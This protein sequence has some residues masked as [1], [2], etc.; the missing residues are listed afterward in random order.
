M[1]VKSAR[2]PELPGCSPG[3]RNNGGSGNSGEHFPKKAT[4]AN[5]RSAVRWFGEFRW[6]REIGTGG[7]K[8][9]LR[10][11][12]TPMADPGAGAATTVVATPSPSGSMVEAALVTPEKKKPPRFAGPRIE[13]V[14]KRIRI[15]EEVGCHPLPTCEARPAIEQ[16]PTNVSGHG[17]CAGRRRRI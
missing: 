17:L 13:P 16:R 12:R 2:F 3:V 8:S 1:L 5:H 15:M 9:A 7:G 11:A 10:N 14:G 6:W 4:C